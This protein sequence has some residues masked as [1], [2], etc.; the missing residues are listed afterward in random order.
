M[1]GKR[2]GKGG[3]GAG[4]GVGYI[5]V[6]TEGQATEGV[7]LGAQRNR[8]TAAAA[9]AGLHLAAI[10]EDAAV[11]GSSTL[12]SRPGGG[13]L[14][15][16]LASGEARTVIVAKLDR[17]GR[18]AVD[19]QATVQRWEREGVALVALDVGVD[20]TTPAGRVMLGMLALFA[21]FER[22]QIAE[23]TRAGLA[24]ARED[25]ARLGAPAFGSAHGAARDAAGRLTVV[26][27]P[28]EAAALARLLK[29]RRDGATWRGVADAMNAAGIPSKRGGAWHATAAMR[30]GKAHGL[31]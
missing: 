20:T 3:S 19:L 28:A 27:Q 12:A 9:A 14:C 22:E 5:R 4:V 11:S 6:S 2:S 30:I 25:G 26:E 16:M 21:Q 18:S 29:L 23:R 15:A 31:A 24:Q 7:S 1:A 8:I 10:I 17:L 13:R